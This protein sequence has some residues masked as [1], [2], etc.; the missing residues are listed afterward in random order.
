MSAGRWRSRALGWTLGSI[1]AALAALVLTLPLWLIP[2]LALLLPPLILG[3]LT[4]R[5]M[6]HDVLAEHADA[7]ER[8]ALLREHRAP[9]LAIGVTC[10]YLGAAPSL[11]W[12]FGV[13]ALPMAPLLLPVYVWLYTLV[14]VFAALWF[15]H[16]MLAA[17]DARRQAAPVL[18]PL[19]VEIE[20]VDGVPMPGAPALP[21]SASPSSSSSSSLPNPPLLP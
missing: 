2:P 17:L 20:P 3:W 15:A 9:L 1:G 6:A 21:S 7:A 13:L 19:R 10:G 5:V 18:Q 11:I 4:Y 14:E 8:A 12:A 16:Y